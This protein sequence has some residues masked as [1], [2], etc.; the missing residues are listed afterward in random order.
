MKRS[1]KAGVKLELKRY[2]SPGVPGIGCDEN[3]DVGVGELRSD[4]A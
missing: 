4:H 3:A 1:Q 2:L